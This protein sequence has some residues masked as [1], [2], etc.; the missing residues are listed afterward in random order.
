MKFHW[1]RVVSC[2]LGMMFPF[3]EKVSFDIKYSKTVTGWL[4]GLGIFLAIA[5]ARAGNLPVESGS[6]ITTNMAAPGMRKGGG[7]WLP[8]NVGSR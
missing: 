7:E 5:L 2:E 1:L 4:S 3:G 8:Q 6:S